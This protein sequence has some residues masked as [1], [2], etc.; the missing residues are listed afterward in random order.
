MKTERRKLK[1]GNLSRGFTLVELLVVIAII[2]IL[3]GFI[4]TAI[5][6]SMDNAKKKRGDATCLAIENA[7][8]NYWHAKGTWP[9]KPSAFKND[10]NMDIEAMLEDGRLTNIVV[11][12]SDLSLSEDVLKDFDT[13][14]AAALK[15]KINVLTSI[16]TFE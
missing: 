12:V 13:P 8:L 5:I 2:G 15:I 10:S 1:T 6:K 3:A 14:T 7:I 4:S 11:T 9:L 16:V